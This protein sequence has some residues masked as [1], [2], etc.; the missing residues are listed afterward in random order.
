MSDDGAIETR[1]SS[2]LFEHYCEEPGCKAWGGW[3]YDIGKGE[4]RWF[5]YEHRWKDYRR[6]KYGATSKA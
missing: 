1:P 4:T 2:V 3:G 6:P 5:C